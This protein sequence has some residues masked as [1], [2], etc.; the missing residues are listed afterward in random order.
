MGKASIDKSA[1]KQMIK[2]DNTTRDNIC[3]PR[4]CRIIIKKLKKREERT[5]A[6]RG[7]GFAEKK[8]IFLFTALL[9]SDMS[10]IEIN[11]RN[12]ANLPILDQ[13]LKRGLS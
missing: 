5:T 2:G 13:S 7:K 11:Y 4:I 8:N 1:N 10:H 12:Q 9:F 6:T 3:N